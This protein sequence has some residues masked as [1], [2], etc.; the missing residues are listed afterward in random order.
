MKLI[1]R[2][3]FGGAEDASAVFCRSGAKLSGKRTESGPNSEKPNGAQGATAALPFF[4]KK[5]QRAR[6][7]QAQKRRKRQRESFAF[8]AV[9]FLLPSSGIL[10]AI[11][12]RF[13]YNKHRMG[14]LSAVY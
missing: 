1:G 6:I 9:V 7:S 3:P 10:L 13:R 12:G 14:G 8:G 11:L 5:G 2:D 4:L